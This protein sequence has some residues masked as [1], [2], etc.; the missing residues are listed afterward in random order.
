VGKTILRRSK[1]RFWGANNKLN[2]NS[3]NFRGQDCW[4]PLSCESEET[5]N[6]TRLG[7]AM[8]E[9]FYDEV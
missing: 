6:E 8:F 1:L 2:N 9:L 3:E 4:G 7:N 5:S